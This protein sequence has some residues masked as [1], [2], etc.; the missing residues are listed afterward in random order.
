VSSGATVSVYVTAPLCPSAER[1]LAREGG[2][3]GSIRVHAVCLPS[4]WDGAR[5]SLST[6]GANARRA[7][8]NSTAVGYLEGADPVAARFS[9]P[10]LDSAGIASIYRS[11]GAAAMTQ[12]LRAIQHAGSSGSLR[13][14]VHDVLR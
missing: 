9:R 2:R 11:S 4:A 8:G 13:E 6:V 3:A 12:L 5:V 10:I 14:S 1:E 7:A